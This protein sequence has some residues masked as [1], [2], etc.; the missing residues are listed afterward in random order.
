MVCSECGNALSPHL[1]VCAQC[2]AGF[3]VKA[4]GHAA[5]AAAL[6]GAPAAAL[7]APRND[8]FHLPEALVGNAAE[9]RVRPTLAVLYRLAVGPAADYYAPR[10]LKFEQAGHSA[11]GWHCLGS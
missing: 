2:N 10:F 9:R 11:P 6:S 4:L 1:P 3:V 5:P 8:A 7:P